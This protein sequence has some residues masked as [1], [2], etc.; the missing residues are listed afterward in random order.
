M[1]MVYVLHS[2]TYDKI[3]IGYSS[4]IEERLRSHNA[5]GTKGWTLK[6]RP[7][8]LVYT[9]SFET[10]REA[11]RREKQLKSSRGREWIWSKIRS[12]G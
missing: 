1:F 9:E 11:L 3:Y 5:L 8:V 6:Y 12:D 7:W 2:P 10:K 4:N